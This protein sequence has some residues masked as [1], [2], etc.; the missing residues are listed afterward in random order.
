M[1]Y[2]EYVLYYIVHI[3]CIFYNY[4]YLLILKKKCL[5]Y[6]M[7]I[8][9]TYLIMFVVKQISKFRCC[10]RSYV[11]LVFYNHV[12]IHS[13]FSNNWMLGLCRTNITL[14]LVYFLS[15]PHVFSELLNPVYIF[16]ILINMFICK[17]LL[18]WV[19]LCW[20]P[21]FTLS[22]TSFCFKLENCLY[23]TIK[24]FNDTWHMDKSTK[25]LF[26]RCWF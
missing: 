5:K 14:S 4:K 19:V 21:S 10:T 2:T 13:F 20:L 3:T 7:F 18:F 22:I 1:N 6:V 15:M 23:R 12:C 16:G 17:A 24:V 9:C 8:Y 26:F 25:C 11:H